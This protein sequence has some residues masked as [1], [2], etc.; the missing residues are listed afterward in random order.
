M[1]HKPELEDYGC[2]W[3]LIVAKGVT[4]ELTL[5]TSQKLKTMLNVNGAYTHIN[6]NL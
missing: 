3:R 4:T 1:E 2:I 6:I 5:G